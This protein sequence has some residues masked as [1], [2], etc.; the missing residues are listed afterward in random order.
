LLVATTLSAAAAGE[1]LGSP[2]RRED[3]RD[4]FVGGVAIAVS[5]LGA[6][7]FALLTTATSLGERPAQ[8]FVS[9]F[10][11]LLLVLS[12][13]SGASCVALSEE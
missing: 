10:S 4:V 6:F 13:A 9:A 12:V 3:G 8:G 1:L 5:I 2:V 7:S 11:T